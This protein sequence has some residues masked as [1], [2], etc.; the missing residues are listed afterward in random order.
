MNSATTPS[1]LRHAV[2]AIL[3]TLAAGSVAGRILAVTRVYEPNLYRPENAAEDPRGLW[4]RSRPEPSATHGDNDRSRWATV[5]ALVDD[6]TYA[7]GRRDRKAT[8]PTAV[9]VLASG[10]SAEA[11][12]LLAAGYTVRTSGSDRGIITEDGWKSID[13]VLRPDT[14]EFYS[15]KPPLLATLA[16][17]EYWLLKNVCGLSITGTQGRWAVVD[18]ILLT[19]NGL[20]LVVYLV[21]LSR[22]LDS[23]GRTD[24]GRCFILGAACFGTMLS[25]FAITFNNHSVATCTALMALY[26]AMRIWYDR[27][28]S[29]V[30]YVTAG[31]F[32]GFT[33]ANELPAAVFAV[34]LFLPLMLRSPALTLLL[35]LPA[36]AVPLAALGLTNYLA[37]G[38]LAFA[39]TKFGGP[40][41]EYEGSYWKYDPSQT[42]HGI[43]WAFQTEGPGGY[44]FNLLIGH[45][46]IFSLTPIYLFSAVAMWQ[47]VFGARRG[48][49]KGTNGT[50]EVYERATDL[51]SYT[52]LSLVISVVVIFFY[53]F[54]VDERS[55][56]YGGWTTGL[57]WLMWL[58]P[59]WLLCMIP[60]VDWCAARRWRRILAYCFL[61]ISVMSAT[62]P[63]TGP[64]RH[65]WLYQFLESQGL[66]R[67]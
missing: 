34:A 54:V 16:A 2:Y 26:A 20:P 35:S 55:R 64:W 63:V 3:I 9:S 67:Y 36:A 12:V 52:V 6:G 33:A 57:R 49:V 1:S 45:H 43:D 59:L 39:Y 38:E 30:L 11:A 24:W 37:I 65:P 62:Y 32:A 31:F 22:L 5:R 8:V 60:I 18:I 47:S 42:R 46:G 56:N 48:A 53:I 44:A 28:S 7:I 21:L 41:Y 50:D 19:F 66:I 27:S 25:P 10:N 58:A 23:F 4:P 14:G 61:A 13:K 15:S 40:W 51:R 29:P 17:G